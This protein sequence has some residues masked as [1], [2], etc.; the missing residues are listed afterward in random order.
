MEFIMGE[1]M[2]VGGIGLVY[3]NTW[4]FIFTHLIFF[5]LV[6]FAV[7]GVISTLKFLIGGRKPKETAEQKWIRTGKF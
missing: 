6:I 4:G 5:A 3:Y 2:S 1:F 7:I